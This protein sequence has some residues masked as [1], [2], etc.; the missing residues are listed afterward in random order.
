MSWYTINKSS[1]IHP[2]SNTDICLYLSKSYIQKER[3]INGSIVLWNSSFSEGKIAPAKWW[4]TLLSWYSKF[5]GGGPPNPPFQKCVVI[6]QSNT[7]QHKTSWKSEVYNSR[8]EHTQLGSTSL[9]C[10]L[11]AKDLQYPLSVKY[12]VWKRPGSSK[13]AKNSMLFCSMFLLVKQ[14]LLRIK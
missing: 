6:L 13:K 5:S 4:L 3:T 8:S 9:I 2:K 12:R 10:D 11:L 7:A 1:L 14:P